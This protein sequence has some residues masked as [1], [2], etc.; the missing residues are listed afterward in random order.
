MLPKDLRPYI[1]REM[2]KAE[3]IEVINRD[4]LRIL[5]Q[6]IDIEKDHHKL[7]MMMEKNFPQ[8]R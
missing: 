6:D 8:N 2:T 4:N 1:I 5:P 3:L 7:F